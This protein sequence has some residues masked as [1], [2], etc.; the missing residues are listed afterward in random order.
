L[1][2]TA[3][4]AEGIYHEHLRHHLLNLQEAGLDQVMKQIVQSPSAVF[5]EDKSVFKL[6]SMGLVKHQG[7]NVI[8]TF[9]LYRQYFQKRL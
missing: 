3:P 4:T 7:D 5:I 9:D 1:L 6:H 8:P 2:E